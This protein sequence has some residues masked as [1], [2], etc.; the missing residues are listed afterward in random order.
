MGSLNGIIFR[1]GL[2]FDQAR[3]WTRLR[4][5]L[6]GQAGLVAVPVC[7]T[8]YWA[9]EGFK[10][11]T[12]G[13]YPHDDDTAFDDDTLY[14]EGRIRIEMA[15]FAP[16]S[17]TVVT[18]RLV[19]APTAAGI[20]FSYQHAMYETGSI[21]EQTDDDTYRVPVFPAIRQAIP[22]GAW[23]EADRP[24]VLCRLASD[25]ELD[26]EFP[27]AGMP[28]PSVNFVEAVDVWN[29]LAIEAA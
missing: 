19:D 15:A 24:T 17:S 2:Q 20:R 13:L 28:R 7:S 4:V 6:G 26:I 16:L 14:Y 25:N 10:D 22:A 11:F 27:S 29:D 1:R 8:R 5:D 12:P 9:A 3:A 18:L 21:I 23:L